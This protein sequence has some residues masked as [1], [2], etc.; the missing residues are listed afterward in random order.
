M[1]IDTLELKNFISHRST[2]L[3][4]QPGIN[5]IVGANATGK[6]SILESISYA[7][8]KAYNKGNVN[9][10]ITNGESNMKI[11]LDFYVR[12]KKWRVQ[13]N[14]ERNR[15]GDSVLLG[16]TNGNL[17]V[18]RRGEQP[19]TEEIKNLIG[20]DKSIFLSSVYVRQGELLDLIEA[21][22]SERKKI[23]GKL[24]GID[25]IEDAWSDMKEV[26]RHFERVKKNT[27]I[28]LREKQTPQKLKETEQ[29]LEKLQEE[30]KQK[31]ATEERLKKEL[32]QLNKKLEK[33]SK[34]RDEYI[35]LEERKTSLRRKKAEKEDQL[36]QIELTKADLSQIKKK[37][38]DTEQEKK[39]ITKQNDGISQRLET[40][41][42]V[43]EKKDTLRIAYLQERIEETRAERKELE[44]EI[45]NKLEQAVKNIR[46]EIEQ[47]DIP[48]LQK[49]IKNEK[50]RIE[51]EDERLHT[52]I[53]ELNNK[54]GEL[55]AKLKRYTKFRESIQ[56]SKGKCPLCGSLLPKKRKERL[57]QSL[58]KKISS[59]QRER[60]ESRKQLG[61]KEETLEKINEYKQQLEN[62]SLKVF[63]RQKRELNEKKTKEKK[64]KNDL[65]QAREQLKTFASKRDV[66]GA[67]LDELKTRI[68]EKQKKKKRLENKLQQM[69]NEIRNLE[70]QKMEGEQ[71]LRNK[72]EI[73]ATLKEI[74]TKLA[75]VNQQYQRLEYDPDEYETAKQ[76]KETK[77]RKLNNLQG[78]LTQKHQKEQELQ[79]KRNKLEEELS[80]FK[81]KKQKVEYLKKEYIPFLKKIRE[82]YHKDKLQ[83]DLRE[84]YRPQIEKEMKTIIENFNLGFTDIELK[85]DWDI[86]V[87]DPRGEKNIDM[88][89]GGEKVGLSIALR[90]AIARILTGKRLELLMLD[91]PTIYLDDD[92]IEGLVD[93]LR[94][95]ESIPQVIVVTHNEKLT[96]CADTLFK[97]RKENNASKVS[98]ATP[99]I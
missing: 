34:K 12:E 48:T 89:S 44:R 16:E 36:S 3:D 18:S 11:N 72:K 51:K 90:L 37:L 99:T 58:K 77:A 53:N 22:P 76:K 15:G 93:V 60:K 69:R 39:K 70:R 57:L 79:E 45:D 1:K 26:V 80:K 84:Y 81:E 13:R 63:N 96:E 85:E 54:I 52:Q 75:N 65:Q 98:P 88:I 2:E 87:Y 32:H 9:D 30:I 40:M 82:T 64:L 21:T 6:T 23:I 86:T 4:F 56:G 73:Q 35:R 10:L 19:V 59:T 61:E 49:T 46:P 91:E 50:E 28:E 83:K 42:E 71:K 94:R 17:K 66:S 27:S 20:L 95:L 7:L 25:Q 68:H 55:K 33:L 5:I 24:I 41:R 74:Q 38:K 47:L 14:R 31:H 8:V 43:R 78:V 97:V 92:R 29:E 62:I 67:S